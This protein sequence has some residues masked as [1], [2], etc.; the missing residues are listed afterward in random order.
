MNM[1]GVFARV[2]VGTIRLWVGAAVLILVVA[3]ISPAGAQSTEILRLSTLD[4]TT[5]NPVGV[6]GGQQYAQSFCTGESEVTLSKVRLPTSSSSDSEPSVTI[7]AGGSGG[8]GETIDTLTNP[9]TFDN[10]ISTYEDF[11]SSGIELDANTSYWLVIHVGDGSDPLTFGV[12]ESKLESSAEAGWSIGD[13]MLYQGSGGWS[14]AFASSEPSGYRMRMAV[15]ARGAVP[16][17]APPIFTDRDCNGV[18][19]PLTLRVDE[20]T[21]A[22]TVVGPVTATDPDNDSLTYS[23][24][25]TDAAEF[26]QVFVINNG[27]G[28]ITVKSGASP[29]YESK[30]SYSITV[31]VT[32]GKDASGN[33]EDP[34]V[35]DDSVTVTVRV[36]NIDEPGTVTLSQATPGVGSALR[37]TLDDPDGWVVLFKVQWS[38]ADTADGAFTVLNFR[39]ISSLR[40]ASYTPGTA[41]EG[42]FLKVTLFYIDRQCRVVN[43]YNNQCRRMAAKTADNAVAT[44]GTNNAPVFSSSNV[45]RSIAENTAAGQNVGAVVTATD[46]DA[47]DTLGYT[48]GGTDAASFDFVESSGQIR[49]KSGVTYDFEAKSSYTV[50]VTAS[51][52]TATAV[53]TVTIGVTDVDEPPSAPATPMVSAVSGSTTSL[54]VSWAA[55]ANAGKPAIANY[56]V[57]YR[58][59]SS[60]AWS[61]G[62]E[63]VAGT[64]ATI[65][66]LVAS[67]DYEARV[68]ATNAEG[69]SG[70]SDPPGAGRTNTPT[71]NA[72]VFSSSNVSRS[73]AENTA[74]GQNVGAVVTDA[75]A[76]D[77]LGYTLG[78][79]DA[80]SFDFVEHRRG[81]EAT[82]A[83]AGDTLGYTLGGADAASFDFVESSGQIRTK[84]GVTYDFEAKSSYTVTVTASDGTATAVATVTIGV[85]DVDEPPSAPATPMVSAVSGS[86]TSLSVSWAAP[87]NAGKPAI[88]NYDVQYRA[89]SSGAWSDGPED[90]AGTSATIT[91]LVAST[92]YE[93][94]VRATNAE[95]DSGWSDPP[96][97]GR[98]NTPLPPGSGFLVGNFGQ[99]VA[100]AAVIT[101]VRDIVGAFTAGALG[102][103]LHNIEFRLFVTLP[104]IDSA[105]LP[106]VTLYRGSVLRTRA[107]TG[108]LVATLS[109]APGSS[110][111]SDT[112]QTVAF[113]APGGTRLDAD[114]TYLVVLTGE[115]SVRVESTTSPAE[116]AGGASGWTIDGV[117]A[118]SSSPYSYQTNSLLLMRVNG[119]AGARTPLTASS[120]DE[121]SSHDGQSEFTFELQFSEEPKEDFS[122]NTLRD[123]AFT[124]TGGEVK[125]ARSLVSGSNVRWEI[126]INPASNGDVTIVLPITTDCTDNGA[127]CTGDGTKL[128]NRLELTVSGPADEQSSQQQQENSAATGSPTISGTAQ[129]GETLTASTT[130][131]TDADG[132][133]NVSYSYQWVT[134][135]GTSDSD[136]ADATASSYTL[137]AADAGKTIK[138]KVIFTDDNGNDESL[139]S[140]ATTAVITANTSATGA[141]TV[142]GTVQVDHTLTAD[143]SGIGDA[144]GLTN[145]SYSYQWIANDGTSDSDI[146][147]GTSS[148][149][150]LVAADA[151]KT[152]KVKVAFTDDAQNQETRTS[153]A[154]AT[155]AAAVQTPLT[156]SIHSEPASHDGQDAFTF[157]LHFSENLEGFSYKTLRDHA[158]TVT[159]GKVATAGRLVSGSNVRWEITIN[160]ASNGDV[161]I[162]LPITTDCADSG[163]VCNGDSRKLSNRLELTVSGPGS[164]QSSQQQEEENSPA[165]GN[166]TISGT[167][168]VGETLTASTT[169]ITDAD[170]LTNVSYSYQ[171]IANDGTSDSDIADA[172]ASSYTLVAADA[173]KTIK[174]KV[175]FTDDNGND[176]SLTSTATTAVTTANTSATG[177]PTISGTVQVDQTL[178][179]DTSGIGDADRLTNVSYSYQWIANDGTSDSDIADATASAYTLVAA[180]AGK[181]IKVKVIFTDDNG[182]DESLTSTATTAVTTANTSATGA[183]TISGTVQVDQTLTADTSGI[184]DADR[185]TNVS[186][187]YQWIANDGT[188]DSDIADATASAYTLVAADAGKT[189]KVKVTFTDDNGNDESL[190]STA[191]TAVIAANTS[192]TGAPTISGTVQVDQTLTADTS[193][194]GDADGLTNVSYSY[195]WI[196][197]D[198]TSDSDIADATSSSYTLVAAD[199][200]KTIKV[201]V[202]FTDD[203]QNQE[204]GTSAATAAVAA[205]V[206]TPLTASIHS[207]PAS[208]DGQDAFTFE[209]HFSENLEGFSYKT[210]R[211]HAF[212]VTGGKVATAG[213]LVS[214]N[215]TKWRIKIGPTSNGDVTIVLPITTDCA[216]SGAV[217]NGDSRKLSNRLE[218]TVSGPGS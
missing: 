95:G 155:V 100:G 210:L 108:T 31:N 90:V 138:V 121:P 104:A 70:W 117:G 214:G 109:A 179:A 110:R 39:Y 130:G 89:G 67:T 140:T 64:S 165:T 26:N 118:G 105:Q 208:H 5:S 166:L 17:M 177:A 172:T 65:T 114:T 99:P 46:A 164:Q 88:A 163:A 82:D 150:T 175:I 125:E 139:T 11:T 218:L 203:A 158:F 173:G 63:D 213:R 68:R 48:L 129:V 183:P 182:N 66:S 193:G 176:E 98:T 204:T 91:S 205:A 126:T 2:S 32:D 103:E 180:D 58:A 122:E 53:A 146:A 12:T 143:T 62:P 96:G 124:V 24:S 14:P 186:Y 141:P 36:N 174:V 128:S 25:G 211:D 81:P 156:A 171:W 151:G 188:S 154:T 37:P 35:T 181:T 162:V 92:D 27:S 209:L 169:G 54:S 69:D 145:V 93:A 215:N 217:C 59:G 197:N 61:D 85:T 112:V 86:T 184:G 73:I 38:R 94:R 4:E 148:S 87:A 116:D 83:D 157:E 33:M 56:D 28:E 8:P 189:I 7:R 185:L 40:K 102:A 119:T 149:Y 78:G 3:D 170:G 194:I 207:E 41:D 71:N 152:I 43:S 23:V 34:A 13:K 77:T 76:G 74:A 50:T 6:S 22:S 160:P 133:T 15:Y 51:D 199:A 80:A 97:A 196:A 20:N 147:D 195:Q 135:D 216:D 16:S 191:T 30:R 178:T 21:A 9:E 159:G 111:P 200:G 47:G 153:A 75:D 134:N 29:N 142:S 57:Q 10:S 168:Q 44:A 144:D 1:R 84:S 187:S 206:Q 55:P 167:A 101:P 123:H 106:S 49:T 131:I 72:P 137:V 19:D 79:T 136:I 192:A 120:P 113:I 107:T 45:S 202:A 52:G 212:T 132:L 115:G 60:G 161:T 190:T 42:K 198:G 201:K 18:A 127:V